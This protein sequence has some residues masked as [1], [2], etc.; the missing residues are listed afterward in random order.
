MPLGRLC[1]GGLP[2]APERRPHIWWPHHSKTIWG[3]WK[4][5]QPPAMAPASEMV[6]RATERRR[7]SLYSAGV[8][9]REANKYNER[10]PTLCSAPQFYLA[11]RGSGSVSPAWNPTTHRSSTAGYSCGAA[12]HTRAAASPKAAP[13]AA[14]RSVDGPRAAWGDGNRAGRDASESSGGC[15]VTGGVPA[16]GGSRLRR[17]ARSR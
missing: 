13:R 10:A 7:Q 17:A 12:R 2:A 8:G 5:N 4:E 15:G 9:R 16:G 14:S 6:S 3:T 11:G 1:A